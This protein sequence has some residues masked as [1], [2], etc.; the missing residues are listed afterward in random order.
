[1]GG[2]TASVKATP[3]Q[4]ELDSS[5]K[6][7]GSAGLTATAK[8]TP[9][10]VTCPTIGPVQ[11]AVTTGWKVYKNEAYHFQFAIPPGWSAGKDNRDSPQYETIA[12]FPPGVT[13]P[14]DDASHQP[15][16]FSMTLLINASPSNPA[17]DQAFKA[18]TQ[19][20]FVGNTKATIYDRTSPDCAEIARVAITHIGQRDYTFY[21]TTTPKNAK[22][23]IA[24]FL[25]TLQS[26]V[27]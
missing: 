20:V 1:M 17:D 11:P 10:V 3:T 8:A 18:E 23:N 25:G 21:M 7:P 26:F 2:N 15:E 22:Q 6:G 4:V 13:V 19:S 12:V 9:V 5:P 14:F 16:A 24:L 27:V